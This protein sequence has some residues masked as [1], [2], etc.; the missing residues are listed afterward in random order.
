MADTED[1][2]S[3][4]DALMFR[5]VPGKPEREWDVEIVE[6]PQLA[7]K[8]AEGWTVL[9][10]EGQV[11]T[12]PIDKHDPPSNRRPPFNGPRRRS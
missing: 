4:P 11:M 5:P 6:A 3:I 8:L 9:I 10:T 7:R 12:D 2:P 1:R